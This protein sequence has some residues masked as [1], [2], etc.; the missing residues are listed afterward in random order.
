[1]Y[2]VYDVSTPSACRHFLFNSS[3]V[4]LFPAVL[5]SLCAVLPPASLDCALESS[6]VPTPQLFLVLIPG[7]DPALTPP[8]S[9][10]TLFIVAE[11]ERA[12]SAATS[13]SWTSCRSFRGSPCK[14][15][16]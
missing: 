1:M 9:L 2:D 7:C 12:H 13:V 15:M 16:H 6:H 5:L 14:M 10:L 8:A 3:P 11:A 4:H